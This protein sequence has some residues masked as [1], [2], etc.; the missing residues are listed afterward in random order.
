MMFQPEGMTTI[1][2]DNMIVRISFVACQSS[3]IQIV[4]M[5]RLVI[6]HHFTELDKHTVFITAIWS[7][8]LFCISLLVLEFSIKKIFKFTEPIKIVEKNCYA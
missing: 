5:V 3:E 6:R 7:K 4:K 8:T 1:R 2:I